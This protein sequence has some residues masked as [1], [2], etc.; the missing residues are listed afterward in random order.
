MDDDL[1]GELLA[2]IGLGDDIDS[3]EALAEIASTPVPYDL[4]RRLRA[5]LETL[6]PQS[7]DPG[8]VLRSL[9]QF[10]AASRSPTA[11]L[12]L[13]ER[14]DRALSTLLRVLGAGQRLTSWL[15]ADPE[16][17]DLVRASD[18]A[19]ASRDTL[20]DE[21][22]AELE[23][24]SLR[25]NDPQAASR[26]LHS[27]FGRER[28][29]IAYA[30]FVGQ[31]TPTVV[32]AQLSVL[33]DAIIESAI[34]FIRSDLVTR[35]GEP[36]SPKGE[37]GRFAAIA[38]GALGGNELSYD[39]P[40]ELIFLHDLCGPTDGD[41]NLSADEFFDRL[42]RGVL[43][44]LSGHVASERNQAST[45]RDPMIV[46]QGE[47]IYDVASSYRSLIDD[48]SL[49]LTITEIHR[50]YQLMGRTWERL[51]YVKSRCVGGD[52][53]LGREFLA[54][55]EPWVYRR[56]LERADIEGMKTLARKFSRHVDEAS[57]AELKSEPQMKSASDVFQFPGGLNDIDSAIGLLQLIN[58]GECQQVRVRSTLDAIKAL[59]D[60]KCLSLQEATLLSD[61]YTLLRQYLHCCQAESPSTEDESDNG[62][63]QRSRIAW[64]LNFRDSQSRGD[65]GKLDEA[66]DV[67]TRHNRTILRHLLSEAAKD[68]EPVPIETELLL[69]PNPE[70]SI[71]RKTMSKYGMSDPLL[72]MNDL[73]RLAGEPVPFLSSRRCRHYLANVAPQLL[74]E[75]GRTPDP[76]A[77]LSTLVEVTD[78]LGG[79]AVLWELFEA[80]PPTMHL[81]V[82]L[83]ACSPYLS[84]ILIRNPGM[85]D[86][87]VDSLLLNRLPSERWLEASST[88]LCRNAADIDSIVA[89][90]KNGAHLE[91]GVRDVLGKEPLEATHAAL[92]TTAE[93]VLRRISEHALRELAER[94]GDPVDHADQE[95]EL[96]MLG[97]GKLGAR[98]PN[99]FSDLDVL[100]LYT[101]DGKTRRRVGGHRRTTTAP[102]FFNELA[103]QIMSR[104]NQ[105]RDGAPLYSLSS[106]LVISGSA[107]SPASPALSLD[108]L[109][110]FFRRGEASLSQRLALCKAR[111][112]SG[113]AATRARVNSLVV[114]LLSGTEWYP[115]MATQIRDLRLS[116]EQSAT[117]DN[118]KRAAGGT[119]D[120]ELITQTLQLRHASK[121]PDLLVPGTT[122]ALQRLSDAGLVDPLIAASLIANYRTLREVES[123]LCL[124]DTPRRHE[125]PDDPKTLKLLAFLMDE[126]SGSEIMTR[127][128]ECR[129]SNRRMF[130]QV[131]QE[132]SR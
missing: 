14:D 74:S 99:Y 109:R 116:M 4:F 48:D 18:G 79:K 55:M 89:S 46:A 77:T 53:T 7:V 95:I 25:G 45:S 41:V 90:F 1:D 12:A 117:D 58:G 123:K 132:L 17:F 100:F 96:V 63:R 97:H 56:Y 87:L 84:K 22:V 24:L 81:V 103:S 19:E 68:S 91:I 122:D 126:P 13:F 61:H 106:S 21:I 6:L 60:T 92:A 108:A 72:A 118:L 16:S 67:A 44:L 39:S 34:Q 119:V 27:V 107:T 5:R 51:R 37:P 47:P 130:N 49:A 9:Q 121:H 82:R 62:S 32:A 15:V 73:Q 129:A 98:E 30:D 10:M 35:Y 75:I 54:L 36:R 8:F 78:S 128:R 52:A 124:L 86:E 101:S 26:V 57:I 31:A 102:H 20:V 88:E 28:L 110:G 71:I 42:A 85:I 66:L 104:V 120:V 69:D 94:Y 83:C 93:S 59:M 40:L 3:R 113:S 127:C 23:T 50:H 76:H 114:E 112:I 11:L 70:E 43:G 2:A 105:S 64:H 29:R 131:I 115:S 65:V 125:I 38:L 111:T 33:A 80:T